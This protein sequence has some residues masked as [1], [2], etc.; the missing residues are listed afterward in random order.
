MIILFYNKHEGI[1]IKYHNNI[2]SSEKSEKKI[3]KK[4]G[5]GRMFTAALV[6]GGGGDAC[7]VFKRSFA[8]LYM[9]LTRL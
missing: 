5:R 9:A 3:K 2:I 1:K 6:Q 4:F 8:S 7:N